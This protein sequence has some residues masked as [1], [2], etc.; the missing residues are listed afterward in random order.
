MYL[1]S[2]IGGWTRFIFGFALV[3]MLF[4]YEKYHQ[5]VSVDRW[6][7]SMQEQLQPGSGQGVQRLGKR[8]QLVSARSW[9]HLADWAC[10]PFTALLSLTLPQ[11]HASLL[12]L[13][14]DKL[15]YNVAGKP[16]IKHGQ[17]VHALANI[18][19]ISISSSL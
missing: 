18:M 6:E 5:Y 9:Y 17:A 10:M 1:V 8:S 15:D 13:F 2:W 12:N 4:Y 16:H 11:L 3:L 14:D 19:S 7:L